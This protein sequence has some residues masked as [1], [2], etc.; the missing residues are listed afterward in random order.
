MV[1]AWIDRNF[2]QFKS[3]YLKKVTSRKTGINWE[4][5][6]IEKYLQIITTSGFKGMDLYTRGEILVYYNGNE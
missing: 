1:W 5:S 4:R 2:N 3:E 6:F